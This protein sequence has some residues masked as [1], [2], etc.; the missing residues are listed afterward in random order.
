M[1]LILKQKSL[2]NVKDSATGRYFPAVIISKEVLYYSNYREGSL[3]SDCTSGEK[4]HVL[5]WNR[6]QGGTSVPW[7]PTF[8]DKARCCSTTETFSMSNYPMSYALLSAFHRWRNQSSERLSHLLRSQSQVQNAKPSLMTPPRVL[9]TPWD[10]S[11]DIYPG[12]M[13]LSFR[14]QMWP[15]T[16]QRGG[17]QIQHA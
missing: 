16:Q 8:I 2:A 1:S 3:L 17:N 4:S 14:P 12:P 11:K 9:S 15:C 13:A 7:V 6:E 5:K 10:N